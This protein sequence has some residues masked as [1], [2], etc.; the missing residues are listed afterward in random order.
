MK[1][2]SPIFA[3]ILLCSFYTIYCQKIS[4]IG[5]GYVGLVT[6][7][8][9]AYLGHEV[10][11]ADIDDNKINLLQAGVIPIVEEHLNTIITS[12]VESK[13]LAFT[14]NIPDAIQKSDIVFIAVGTPTKDDGTSDTTALYKV[15]EI[16]SENLNNYKIICIKS[17]IPIGTSKKIFDYIK[18]RSKNT[19]FDLV[20]NPEFLREGQAVHDFLYPNRIVIGTESL[21]AQEKMALVYASFIENNIPFLTTDLVSAETIKYACNAFLATKIAYINDISRLCE[22]SGACISMVQQGMMLDERIGKSFLNPGPGFGGSCFPKD[23]EALIHIGDSFDVDLK[24]VKSCLASNA[25]HKETIIKKIISALDDDL[26]NKT[27]T[28][29]GLAFKAGTDD[30]R[31]SPAITIIEKLLPSGIK[32]KVYDPA[33][34]N[35]MQKIFP[36]LEY[37]SSAHEALEN[38]DLTVILTEWP[39]FKELAFEKIVTKNKSLK[40]IDT[41]NILDSR[42]M[43]AMGC[44]YLNA[45]NA[46]VN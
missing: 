39:E 45:G 20:F 9:L 10:I 7:A 34:M 25:L 38:S 31:C 44:Y 36:T 33:A 16:I 28:L 8:C 30:V 5:T 21:I 42:M 1:H 17:T 3:S 18:A 46:I 2:L 6:G 26:E 41:R 22:A 43:R 4:V 12:N 23:C 24:I 19:Q 29:L 13:K 35:N 15:A 40:I 32:I 27:V 14:T 37:C 11:C